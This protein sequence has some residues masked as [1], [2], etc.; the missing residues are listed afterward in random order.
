MLLCGFVKRNGEGRSTRLIGLADVIIREIGVTFI[1][2][3]IGA[4]GTVS[5]LHL[6]YLRFKNCLH[7]KKKLLFRL[8]IKALQNPNHFAKHNGGNKALVLWR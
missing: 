8:P 7:N 6:K 1:E 4:P 2:I 5:V 3:I